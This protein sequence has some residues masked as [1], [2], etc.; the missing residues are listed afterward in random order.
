MKC[1][2]GKSTVYT[3]EN[4]TIRPDKDGL[5][6]MRWKDAKWLLQSIGG[7]W[8]RTVGNLEGHMV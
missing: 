3:P 2:G 8:S 1:D 6:R 5:Y 4:E 7:I